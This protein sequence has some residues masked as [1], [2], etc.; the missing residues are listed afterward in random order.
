MLKIVALVEKREDLSWEE[1]VT[2]WD[3]EHVTEVERVSTLQRYTIA[4][5]IN[6]DD[7][8]YDGIA[9]L[10]FESTDDIREGFTDDLEADISADE[11]EFL[12]SVDTF[13]AAE[14]TQLDRR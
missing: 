5:A 14:Q 8:P 6:P 9:E 11:D 7:A 1:F 13:V 2:Y 4:P 10:Y 3:E 12:A